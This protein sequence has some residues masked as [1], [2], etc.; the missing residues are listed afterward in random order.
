[1]RHAA[2]LD[3]INEQRARIGFA[4]LDRIPPGERG[5]GYSCPIANALKPVPTPEPNGEV[6]AY[7]DHAVA[8]GRFIAYP[9]VVRDFVY[10]FD[11]SW[12][13]P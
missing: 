12:C 7:T 8:F 10:A 6:Y 3:W 4:E 9:P 11:H 1:M 13:A 5:T 2:V